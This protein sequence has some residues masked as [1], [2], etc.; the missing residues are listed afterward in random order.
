MGQVYF[1]IFLR[2]GPFYYYYLLLG[3]DFI[4]QTM[5]LAFLLFG[6]KSIPLLSLFPIFLLL[7]RFISKPSDSFM[8]DA[9]RR[10]GPDAF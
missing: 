1:F 9:E 5:S 10:E 8:I 6:P 3:R 2:M 4:L 7:G